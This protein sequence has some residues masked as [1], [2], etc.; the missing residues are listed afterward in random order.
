MPCGPS[1]QGCAAAGA[2][3]PRSCRHPC[4]STRPGRFVIGGPVGD[5]GLTGRKIIVDTYGG[6]H[7][8]AAARSPART[9]PRLTARPPT[10]RGTSPRTW[11]PLAWRTASKSRLPTPSGGQAAVAAHRHVRHREDPAIADPRP[12]P[13]RTS[14]S[15]RPPSAQPRPA[16]PIYHHRRLW[17]LR[18]GRPNFPGSAPTS[19]TA[20]ASRP[21]S[22][23]TESRNA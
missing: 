12:G 3:R 21:A 18:P 17:P 1:R 14:T 10:P 16:P 8:T 11:W 7:A 2:L 23:L 13:R 19:P 9:R 5:A 20:C 6:R 22:R 4:W 15:A